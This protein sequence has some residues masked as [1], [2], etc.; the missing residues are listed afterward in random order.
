MKVLPLFRI[1][2]EIGEI[3]DTQAKILIAMLALGAV[4][5]I[6]KKT[7]SINQS[8]EIVFNLETLI[9]C[10]E[11]LNDTVLSWAISYGMEL[12]SIQELVE[13]PNEINVACG[14]IE[15]RLNSIRFS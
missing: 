6:R 13:D 8:E 7:I 9:F 5:S 15:E 2:E 12:E 3:G 10:E 14:E 4:R 1:I 11:K